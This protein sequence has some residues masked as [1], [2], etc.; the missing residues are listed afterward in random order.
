MIETDPLKSDW[1]DCYLY[2]HFPIQWTVITSRAGP[3]CTPVRIPPASIR[4]GWAGLW[5]QI[6]LN[7]YEVVYDDKG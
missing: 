5:S 3:S 7:P 6:S 4:T 1:G 2:T